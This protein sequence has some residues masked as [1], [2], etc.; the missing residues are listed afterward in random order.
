MVLTLADIA[1]ATHATCS[2]EDDDVHIEAHGIAW[3]SRHVNKGDLFIALPGQRVD[4][5]DYADEAVLG[6]ACAVLANRPLEIDA[7]VLIVEDTMQALSSLAAFYRERLSSTV[8]GVTGSCGKTSTKQMIYDIL[9]PDRSVVATEANQNNE[10]GVPVTILRANTDVDFVVVEMGMRGRGQIAKLADIAQPEWGIISN[11][12][13][14]HL[15]ILNSQ[16]AIADAKAE[17]FEALPESNGIAFVNAADPFSQYVCEHARLVERGV[18]IVLF[19]GSGQ[20]G[21]GPTFLTEL[22]DQ[23]PVSPFVWASDISLSHEGFATFTVNAVG[24]GSL[25]Y[26]N[27]NGSIRITLA[28]RGIHN[29]SNACSAIAIG[30]FSGISLKTCCSR[31]EH[32]SAVPGRQNVIQGKNEII[33]LDDSYNANPDSMQ[34]AITTMRY[35]QCE[36]KK[37]A[38]L[39]DMLELGNVSRK[40]HEEVGEKVAA[41]DIDILIGVGDYSNHMIKAAETKGMDKSHLFHCG[42]TKEAYD[43]LMKY[44]EPGDLVLCKA[45]HSIGLHDIVQKLV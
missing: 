26:E 42:S 3:D 23:S 31:I 41:S 30:L 37:I 38:I 20:G 9:H 33:V 17:L 32:C 16:E 24:F 5:H 8:I 43:I 15:E 40:S 34:A 22:D 7:P 44:L 36:G 39:G 1:L 21:S 25:G 45:S 10:L 4:G 2:K 6:G 14:S 11:I 18:Q 29:V 28:V 35:M 19:D 27:A 12:G 13:V